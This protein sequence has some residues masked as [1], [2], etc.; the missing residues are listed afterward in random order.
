[1][2]WFTMQ[3]REIIEHY[4]QY[5][6]NLSHAERIEIG[7]QQ[8]FN[9]NYPFFSTEYKKE[10]ET[11][12][13]RH[14]Y[15]R[16]IGRETEGAFKFELETWLRIN[17]PYYN[18]LFESEQLDFDPF[19]SYDL[20]TEYQRNIEKEEDSNKTGTTNETKNNTVTGSNSREEDLVKTETTTT[21][22]ETTRTGSNTSTGAIST[23]ATEEGESQS[24]GS[25]T[26]EDN[27]FNREISSDQPDSRLQLT[28]GD[29]GTGVI[30]YANVIKE[31]KNENDQEQTV[32]ST[33]TTENTQNTEQ[34]SS[35]S[36]TLSQSD[37]VNAT[38]EK[39][40]SE[41][42]TITESTTLSDNAIN[43][44][45]NS[46]SLLNKGEEKENYSEVR[47]G[48]IGVKTYSEMLNEFRSTFIRIEK[49]MFDEM[50]AHLFM[51]I[52]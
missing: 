34:T 16:E 28:T 36:E 35:S 31:T 2:A 39:E 5:Q 4:T 11:N 27:N 51:L 42:K 37:E 46:E 52:Y 30:E 43:A 48:S 9:F 20:A 15:F 6:P 32:E 18:K 10:F 40:G 47:R 49:D 22:G 45:N 19:I 41:N 17:A 1:M 33:T 29:R 50:S 14:F 21:E 23:S 24:N 3:L 26:T 44:I 8:L 38:E 13:I 25:T 12:F 7:R